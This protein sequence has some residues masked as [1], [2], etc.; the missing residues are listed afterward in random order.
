MDRVVEGAFL[1]RHAVVDK[2]AGAQI[3]P[4]HARP[5]KSGIRRMASKWVV[6]SH[7]MGPRGSRSL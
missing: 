2:V 1:A 4:A 5:L 6:A 3:K 7:S